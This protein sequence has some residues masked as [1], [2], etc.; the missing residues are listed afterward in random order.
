MFLETLIL[1]YS[2]K[3]LSF[4][5][6]LWKIG[7]NKCICVSCLIRSKKTGVYTFILNQFIL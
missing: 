2:L 3:L 1:I 6:I 4:I 7:N 5:L